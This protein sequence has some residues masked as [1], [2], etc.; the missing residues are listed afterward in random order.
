MNHVKNLKDFDRRTVA[1]YYRQE[2]ERED[3]L[4]GFLACYEPGKFD[5][6]NKDSINRQVGYYD[7]RFVL[8][9][10]KDS[11]NQVIKDKSLTDFEEEIAENGDWWNVPKATK[12]TQVLM[13]IYNVFGRDVTMVSIVMPILNKAGEFIGVFN[14]DFASTVFQDEVI[15]NKKE[16]FKGNCEILIL[17]NNNNIVA[18]SRTEK[19]LGK[20]VDS[21]LTEYPKSVCSNIKKNINGLYEDANI[22]YSV[23]TFSYKN[24][25]VDLWKCVILTPKSVIIKDANKMM[26]SQLGIGIAAI[27]ISII[28][29]YLFINYL[30]KPL[31]ILKSTSLE[32]SKGNLGVELSNMKADEM[33]L[34][35]ESFAEMLTHLKKIIGS[36]IEGTETI[37]NSSESLSE[38]SHKISQG[39]NEQ[40]A[41]V[42]EISATIE[43]ISAGIA[44]N[45]E[46]T[47]ATEKIFK[48]AHK[49][50]IDVN[51]YSQKALDAS[52]QITE[53]IGIV[54]DIAAQTNILALNAAVEAA[55]AGAAG[56][57]FA[58]VADEVR[59]LAEKSKIAAEEIVNLA[60]NSS[61]INEKASAKVMDILPKVETIAKLINEI[62]IS[63]KEQANGTNQV[64]SSAQY[65]SQMSQQN[66]ASGEELASKSEELSKKAE[67][68]RK[69]I[70]YF[71]I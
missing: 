50:M 35:F 57:G 67:E 40:S 17:D 24:N 42:E 55:R 63:S 51:N 34:V 14:K 32:I 56:A 61:N 21:L 69:I 8:Y 49:H 54:N 3:M 12:R 62:T 31:D 33:G 46:N 15:T 64:N 47:L 11:A 27:I 45:S 6:K 1:P 13:A 41:S 4:I 59:K 44:Q 70:A 16:L 36:V 71:K 19:N 25:D 58:V 5:G 28:I 52:K 18:D 66:A 43:E 26:Y 22:N 65:L 2:M 30:L 68:L 53:K 38:I 20:G 48:E 37:S 23:Q 10:Y 9:F 60:L 39:A 7:G 29:V